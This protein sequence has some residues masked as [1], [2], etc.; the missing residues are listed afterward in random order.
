MSQDKDRTRLVRLADAL[1]NEV[2]SAPEEEIASEIDYAAITETRAIF[3]EVK[4][5]FAGRSLEMAKEEL[6]AWRSANS[7]GGTSPD[8]ASVREEFKKLQRSDPEFGRKI[9]LAARNGKAPTDA[10]VGGLVEDWADLQRLDG[11]DMPE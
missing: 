7:R 10:D 1:M 11:E 3:I 9:T 4:R 6:A 2:L 5:A 8:P